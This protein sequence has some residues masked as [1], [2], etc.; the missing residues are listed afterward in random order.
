MTPV[1]SVQEQAASP[2]ADIHI[3]KKKSRKR[4]VRVPVGLGYTESLEVRGSGRAVA[5]E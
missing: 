4:K 1:L 2:N 5:M 3:L